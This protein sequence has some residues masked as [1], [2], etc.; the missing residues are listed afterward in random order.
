MTEQRIKNYLL[1]YTLMQRAE[2][3]CDI[4][5]GME[6]HLFHNK[7]KPLMQLIFPATSV[8]SNVA[9]QWNIDNHCEGHTPQDLIFN[10]AK[11]GTIFDT[12]TEISRRGKGTIWTDFAVFSVDI[13]NS[14]V[15]K[16]GV[17][18]GYKIDTNA[19]VPITKIRDMQETNITEEQK[20]LVISRCP[21]I[22]FS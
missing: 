10:N 21:Y 14:T 22:S 15:H 4:Q 12:P 13:E 1:K 16:N 11:K 3:D 9:K 7:E 6:F 17:K 20:E 8:G 2:A 19:E 18:F 5:F